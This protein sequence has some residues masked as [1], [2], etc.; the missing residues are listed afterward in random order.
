MTAGRRLDLHVHSRHSPDGRST[1]EE[2]VRRASERAL[3]G[4]ALTDH[5]SVAGLGDLAR[6]AAAHPELRLVPG[7]EVSTRDGHLLALGVTEC[8]PVGR[9]VVETAGWVIARG[10]VAVPAHPFRR[11]HGVGPTAA[12]A[13]APATIEV[14]NGHNTPRANARA[15]ALAAVRGW[16]STGGSDAHRTEELGQAWT[17][18]PEGADSVPDVLEAI[19]RG[20]TVA[21]GGSLAAVDR[22]GVSLRS[23]FLRLG[24][25]LRPV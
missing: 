17:V 13:C 10:G 16:G 9:P 20:R 12:A 4:F 6:L 25:G 8:P 3:G 5:N 18:F 7:V 15:A 22:W 1:V 24:R 23:F 2:L 19:R 14:T 21:D 11:V